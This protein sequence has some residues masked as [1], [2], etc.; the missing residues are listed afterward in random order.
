MILSAPVPLLTTSPEQRGSTR[1]S[2]VRTHRTNKKRNP[3]ATD[4]IA[5]Y[6]PRRQ[7]G[8]PR[9]Q[10]RPSQEMSFS[11]N[12]PGFTFS[13][14]GM[15]GISG[16]QPAKS[17]SPG[18]GDTELSRWAPGSPWAAF[19]GQKLLLTLRWNLLSFSSR[20]LHI[21]DQTPNPLDQNPLPSP[22][23][24]MVPEHQIK[25]KS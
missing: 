23:S 7:R 8:F 1:P 5:R 10:G 21:P 14:P 11:R 15:V 12:K 24:L 13:N 20:Q 19:N 2:A 25:W 9:T 4:F 16:D 18:A 6:L 22:E 17:G 3:K